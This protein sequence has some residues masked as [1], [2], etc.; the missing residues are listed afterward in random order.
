MHVCAFDVMCKTV[1]FNNHYIKYIS[2]GTY[3]QAR[4]YRRTLS[5]RVARGY[6]IMFHITRYIYIN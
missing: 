2:L 4:G 3:D 6:T 1:P 5:H